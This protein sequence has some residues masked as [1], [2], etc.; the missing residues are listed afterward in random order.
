MATTETPKAE[1]LLRQVRAELELQRQQAT[2]DDDATTHLLVLEEIFERRIRLGSEVFDAS[3]SLVQFDLRDLALRRRIIRK[4]AV[5]D[6]IN[7]CAVAAVVL[8]L[9]VGA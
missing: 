9:A 5:L 7:A 1:K 4:C 3:E 8:T 6:A 2:V